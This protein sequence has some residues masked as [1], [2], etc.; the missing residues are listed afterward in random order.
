ML[1][2]GMIVYDALYG[3]CRHAQGETHNWPTKTKDKA[4]A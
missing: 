4:Y 2:Q 3:W 1:A